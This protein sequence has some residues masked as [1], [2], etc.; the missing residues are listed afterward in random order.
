MRKPPAGRS[1][2]LQ[3][4]NNNQASLGHHS[5]TTS[6]SLLTPSAIVLFNCCPTARYGS[7]RRFR[8]LAALVRSP[9][10]VYYLPRRHRLL[11]TAEGSR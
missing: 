3:P 11:P 5:T 1:D 2:F 10:A 7:L 9:A 6:L 4:S 8:F